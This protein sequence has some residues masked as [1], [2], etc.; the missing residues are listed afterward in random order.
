MCTFSAQN[1]GNI[2]TRPGQQVLHFGQ[3]LNLELASKIAH[4][5]KLLWHVPYLT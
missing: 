5:L 1:M 3:N 2:H 4:M